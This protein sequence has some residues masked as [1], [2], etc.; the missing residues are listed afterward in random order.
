MNKPV[1][2]KD[3]YDLSR[4]NTEFVREMIQIFLDHN[5]IDL[6]DLENSISK[7]EYPAIKSKAHKMKTSLGFMGLKH[8][9]KPLE[10]IETLAENKRETEEIQFIYGEIKTSCDQAMDELRKLLSKLE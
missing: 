2:L 10:S 1:D 3:L 8:L 7:K 6:K 9:L 5:P 4:G